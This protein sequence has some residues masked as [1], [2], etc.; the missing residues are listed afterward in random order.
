VQFLSFGNYVIQVG[1]GI[2]EEEAKAY[3]QWAKENRPGRIIKKLEVAPD[4]D[5]EVII[6]Y[7]KLPPFQRIRRITGY[8]VGDTTRWNSAKLAELEDRM[9]HTLSKMEGWED[10]RKDDD[11]PVCPVCGERTDTFYKTI[12]GEIVGCSECIEEVDAWDYVEYIEN[13]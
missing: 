12:D 10:M 2:S 11:Y 8:L 5:K 4:N 7:A 3:I 6:H 1:E 9:K 13:E